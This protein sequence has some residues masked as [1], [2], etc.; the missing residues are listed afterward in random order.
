M[1]CV[2]RSRLAGGFSLYQSTRG[3]ERIN[4]HPLPACSGCILYV[5]PT[6]GAG[7]AP[8][9]S[10]ASPGA[11]DACSACSVMGHPSDSDTVRKTRTL[12]ERLGYCPKTRTLSER[13]GYCP[14]DSDTV[15][16]TRILSER[17]HISFQPSKAPLVHRFNGP[18]GPEQSKRGHGTLYLTRKGL[19]PRLSLSQTPPFSL[20]DPAFLSLSDFAFLS[21]RPRLSLSQTPTPPFSLSDPASLSLRPAFLSLRPRLSLSQTRLSLSQTPPFS[22]SDPDFLSLRPRLS[23]SQ[24][25]LPASSC[26]PGAS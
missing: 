14:K 26:Q 16:K 3:C 20:S 25:G 17:P 12:S 23:L 21:L 15:R 4:A 7:E 5:A 18:D 22:L 2:L 8:A 11:G 24:Q 19:R 13:L 9:C 6:A 1:E 10:V